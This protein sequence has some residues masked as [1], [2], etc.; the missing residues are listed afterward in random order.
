[1]RRSLYPP[2][3]IKLKR[4]E[5]KLLDGRKLYPG[6]LASIHTELSDQQRGEV[7]G[8][9]RKA[10]AFYDAFCAHKA[11]NIKADGTQIMSVD[12]YNPPPRREEGQ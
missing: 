9:L 5:P 6:S 4:P 2:S 10:I 8:Q 3:K 1:M 11:T 12:E 7:L